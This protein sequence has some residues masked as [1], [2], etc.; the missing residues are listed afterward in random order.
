MHSMTLLMQASGSVNTNWFEASDEESEEDEEGI[1]QGE[2][3]ARESL[4]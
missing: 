2:K 1:K 4:D 3:A